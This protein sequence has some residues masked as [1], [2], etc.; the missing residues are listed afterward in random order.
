MSIT[1]DERLFIEQIVQPQSMTVDDFKEHMNEKVWE[2]LKK[3][4]RFSTI[5]DRIL[6]VEKNRYRPYDSCYVTKFIT[7]RVDPCKFIK[8]IFSDL[9]PP[10]LTFI[11]FHFLFEC[12]PNEDDESK[13]DDLKLQTAS[14]ASAINDN[15]KIATRSDYIKLMGEFE[16][17][18]YSD[19]LTKAYLHHLE[20]YEYQNSGLRPYQLL[21]LVVHVQ[22]LP[23]V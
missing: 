11:D 8:D 3:K 14:K 20:L 1:T 7:D 13:I 4:N 9:S 5:Q 2:F 16:N 15:F 23:I 22:R 19:L 6:F 12:N 21:S 18:T 17:Q 10:F